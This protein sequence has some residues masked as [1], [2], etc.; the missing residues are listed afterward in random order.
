MSSNEIDWDDPDALAKARGDYVENAADDGGEGTAA[1]PKV[2]EE[3]KAGDDGAKSEPETTPEPEATPEGKAEATP[4]GKAAPEAAAKTEGELAGAVDPDADPGDKP[5]RKKEPML[6][7][8][9]YDQQVAKTKALEAELEAERAARK[10]EENQV[11]TDERTAA[12]D[13]E[14]DQLDAKLIEAIAD[15]RSED[16]SR[17]RK[18]MRRLDRELVELEI[19]QG[20]SQSTDAIRESIR[21]DMVIDDVQKAHEQLNEMSEAFDKDLAD[22][23]VQLQRDLEASGNYSPSK[24]LLRAVELLI[25][26]V[27]EPVKDITPPDDSTD[28]DAA[29]KRVAEAERKAAERKSAAVEKAVQTAEQQP[30]SL[31]NTGTD[32]DSN[33]MQG[34]PQASKLNDKD[35]AALPEETLK[36]MRGDYLTA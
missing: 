5:A 31:S 11:K 22:D 1:V 12:I 2:E 4:E 26:E 30:A 36:R 27:A 29:A 13:A 7:K 15:N 19:Q 35:F 28:S 32:S 34:L 21:L 16:A 8:H 3:G 24:A 23:V 33:G 25:P 18:D 9:R 14:L 20:Q 17:I 6:P 10:Q